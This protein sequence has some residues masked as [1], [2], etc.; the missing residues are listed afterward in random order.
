[1][2]GVS[3]DLF[4]KIIK[5][6]QVLLSLVHIILLIFISIGLRLQLGINISC[7]NEQNKTP[8]FYLGLVFLT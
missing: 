2:I 3:L 5:R 1:M 4:G 6:L 8:C 7:G